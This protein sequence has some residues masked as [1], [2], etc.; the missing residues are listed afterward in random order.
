MPCGA[1]IGASWN[2]ALTERVAS[3]IGREAKNYGV[4]VILGPAMNHKRTP[5]GGRN[6]EY[7]SE[8]P[9]LTGKLAA[10]Y[11]RGMQKEGVAACV[12][13]YCANNT[14]LN[15]LTVNIEVEEKVLREIYLKGFEIAVKEGA[16]YCVMGAYNK[17]GGRYCC[18]NERLIDGI[19]RRE[20]GFDG[21]VVSDWRAVHDRAA[22]LNAGCDLEMPFM[23][24]KSAA[25]VV[26]A[27]RR[28][29]LPARKLE[30][31]VWRLKRL[32]I[33]TSERGGKNDF[34]QNYITAKEMA[35]ESAVLLKN[36]GVLPISADKKIA[37]VGGRSVSPKFQGSGSARL[38]ALH[39]TNLYEELKKR[40]KTVRYAEGSPRARQRRN[41]SPK[42]RRRRETRTSS[43]RCCPRRRRTTR[44]IK[45]ARAWRWKRGRRS[46]SSGSRLKKNPSCSCCSRGAPG[47]RSVQGKTFRRARNLSC[48]FRRGRSRRPKYSR[49]RSIPRAGW[50]K[51]IPNAAKTIPPPPF[52]GAKIPCATAKA[53]SRGTD[54]TRPNGC[55]RPI[56]SAGD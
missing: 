50:R 2:E 48:G 6:F 1:A 53:S 22:A 12:K 27:V 19:L 39:V 36:D 10:A 47:D 35:E 23:T 32:S 24:K 13:H 3:A 29:D 25:D 46:C 9:L 30:K 41:C 26:R 54:I 45:P 15:R 5:I 18:E 52:T 55:A 37:L 28:N 56:R 44:K 51:L 20:W 21:V 42:P 17:I 31:S 38:N 40:V 4:D 11:V 43:W 7:F 8:D 34:T 14:E 33:L 16:P 49:E